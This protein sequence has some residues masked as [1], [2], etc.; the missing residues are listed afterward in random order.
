MTLRQLVATKIQDANLG[1]KEVAAAADLEAIIK[2]AVLAPGCYIY[3]QS[4]RAHP[5]TAINR[6]RQKRAEFIGLVVVTRNVKDGKGGGNADES[7]G[8][9]D[10]LMEQLLGHAP[11]EDYLPMEYV[12]GDLI[13]L[14]DGSHYWREIYQSSRFI[15]A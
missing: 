4:N 8:F 1:F 13:L 7:E 9:C 11:S 10:L 6:V 15:S 12:S 14:K 3:R 2:G 5:N